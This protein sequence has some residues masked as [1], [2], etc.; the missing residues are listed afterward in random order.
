MTNGTF[1]CYLMLYTKKVVHSMCNCYRP[2]N[3]SDTFVSKCISL[4]LNIKKKKEFCTRYGTN[5]CIFLVGD[6]FVS[7]TNK[8]Q[9]AFLPI[10]CLS[11]YSLDL[12]GFRWAF[13]FKTDFKITLFPREDKKVN[14]GKTTTYSE[15]S[16]TQLTYLFFM[17][18]LATVRL[19]SVNFPF[20]QSTL[21]H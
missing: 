20:S 16:S 17:D 10:F 1:L 6:P 5:E 9:T 7:D 11:K 15:A 19:S 3:T 18:M 4:H 21:S 8:R 12:Q 14:L 13:C 2:M